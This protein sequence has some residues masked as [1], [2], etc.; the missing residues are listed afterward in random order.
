MFRA[1]IEKQGVVTETE[2]IKSEWQER[3]P[4]KHDIKKRIF[5]MGGKSI[6]KYLI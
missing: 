2:K 6:V 4:E 3:K 5:R 1:E